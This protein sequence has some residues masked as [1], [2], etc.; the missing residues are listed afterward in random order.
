MKDVSI[1]LLCVCLFI[2]I[3]FGN[4]SVNDSLSLIEVAKAEKYE[5]EGKI[6]KASE[7]FLK[8]MDLSPN[9]M[10]K[11]S[12]FAYLLR[13]EEYKLASELIDEPENPFEFLLVAEFHTKVGAILLCD[14]PDS[15][16]EAWLNFIAANKAMI[17]SEYKDSWLWSQIK[18]GLVYSFAISRTRHTDSGSD[19]AFSVFRMQDLNVMLEEIRYAVELDDENELAQTVLDS[20]EA[21]F[22][23]LNIKLPAIKLLDEKFKEHKPQQVD[24]IA[25]SDSIRSLKV[26]KS[27]LPK[28]MVKLMAHLNTYDE[29]SLNLDYSGSM[30]DVIFEGDPFSPTRI[31]SMKEI[32]KFIFKELEPNIKVGMMSIENACGSE[33]QLISDVGEDR[34]KMLDQIQNLDAGGETPLN[35]R[36]EDS[37]NLFSSD[38]NRKTILLITDGVPSCGGVF[39]ICAITK[40][41]KAKGIDIVVLSLLENKI[42]M[43]NAYEYAIYKCITE[44]KNNK[45]FELDENGSISESKEDSEKKAL[46]NFNFPHLFEGKGHSPDC[47]LILN[48]G[49]VNSKQLDEEVLEFIKD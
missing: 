48:L 33:P 43:S 8:A 11:R 31:E 41:L 35:E 46:V 13:H 9:F 28:N 17:R 12:Y 29:I 38:Q 6:E 27:K 36:I 23:L 37:A 5:S 49:D 18:T 47:H 7:S 20:I 2:N 14:G 45:L 39:D 44:D 22:A 4:A 16:T 40:R 32:N 19:A 1:M 42:D 25:M 30:G 26:V 15:A 10:V 24:S 34:F 3:N 21:K